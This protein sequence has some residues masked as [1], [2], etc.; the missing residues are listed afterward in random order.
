MAL[1][2]R[3]RGVAGIA[4]LWAGGWLMLGVLLRLTT[5]VQERITGAEHAESSGHFIQH[6]FPA[7]AHWLI[8][9]AV[10]GGSFAIVLS[11]QERHRGIADL[12]MCRTIMWGALGVTL[13]PAV[14][15][16]REAYDYGYNGWWHDTAVLLGIIA[17]FGGG[18]T[19]ATLAL[20]RL[21]KP[22][23]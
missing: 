11:I 12:T 21:G 3:L 23:R 20:V 8:F 18:S 19:A 16:I 9:G 2:S 15:L 4:G 17:V 7:V 10:A 5:Y 22:Q 1:W 14:V 6:M 13:L